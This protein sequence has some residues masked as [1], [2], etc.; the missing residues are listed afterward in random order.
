[1]GPCCVAAAA[2]FWDTVN[3][4]D[5]IVVLVA[6]ISAGLGFWSGFIW[7]VIRVTSWLVAFWV[8]GQ[9][10]HPMA[11]HLGSFLG[12]PAR[13]VLSF[14]LLL[15]GALLV[16]YLLAHLGRAYVNALHVEA[17]DR[18]LGGVLGAAKALLICGILALMLVQY[19]PAGTALHSLVDASPLASQSARGARLLWV[20]MPGPFIFS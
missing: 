20:L 12:E 14:S 18:L 19:L 15:L 9:F 6:A 16:L 17:G 13:L 8:A 4:I 7:Q 10:H 2:S 1:M 11:Q 3:W 5:A